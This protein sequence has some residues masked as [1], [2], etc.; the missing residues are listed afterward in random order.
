MGGE[1]SFPFGAAFYVSEAIA[2]SRA[3]G[4]GRQSVAMYFFEHTS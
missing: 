4:A 3:I 1:F 2:I